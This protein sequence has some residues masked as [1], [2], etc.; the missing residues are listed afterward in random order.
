[1]GFERETPDTNLYKCFT[2]KGTVKCEAMKKVILSSWNMCYEAGIN[3]V[4]FL[5]NNISCYLVKKDYASS[6]SLPW[7]RFLEKLFKKC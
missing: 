3:A 6:Y 5:G 4:N 1:M 2:F 7:C